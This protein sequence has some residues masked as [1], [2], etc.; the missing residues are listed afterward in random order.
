MNGKEKVFCQSPLKSQFT[1]QCTAL[2]TDTGPAHSHS[3]RVKSKSC[4]RMR[5]Q[6]GGN[7]NCTHRPANLRWGKFGKWGVS[8][9]QWE[10]QWDLLNNVYLKIKDND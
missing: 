3:V 7:S 2:G 4:F 1:V 9:C 10:W 6:R 8:H 5:R